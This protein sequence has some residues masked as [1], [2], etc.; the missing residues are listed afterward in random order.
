MQQPR[1][2]IDPQGLADRV[3]NKFVYR[4]WNN[5]DVFYNDNITSLLGNYS[6]AFLRLAQYQLETEQDNEKAL[7][8]LDHMASVIPEE[9][10]PPSDFRYSLMIGQMYQNAGRPEELQ[11]RLDKVAWDPKTRPRERARFIFLYAQQLK[12]YAGAVKLARD[13]AQINPEM[14]QTYYSYLIDLLR[15][16][17]QTGYSSELVDEWLQF[18]ATNRTA[19]LLQKQLQETTAKDTSSNAE[20]EQ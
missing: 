11:K 17:G 15:K 13:L 20:T 1:D 5:P 2:G 19:L 12:D 3:L 4:N 14:R 18:D 10:I 8:A 9:V 6:S 16:A 7:K